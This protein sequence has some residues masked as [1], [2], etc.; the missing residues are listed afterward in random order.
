MAI[1]AWMTSV[2][3]LDPRRKAT[4]L[5]AIMTAQGIGAIIRAPLGGLMYQELVPVGE[6][7]GLGQTFGHYSPFFG[8]ALCVT[9]GWLISLRA[10][11]GTGH[12]EDDED[13]SNPGEPQQA[14]G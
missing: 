3:N 9:I 7:L 11:R 1:P 8:C 14:V 4:N 10:L 5:G 6:K 2:T 13:E 12:I